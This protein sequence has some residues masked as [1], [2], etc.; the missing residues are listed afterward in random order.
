LGKLSGAWYDRADRL[1]AAGASPG[2][3]R[4]KSG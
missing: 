1:I 2:L 4:Q 3:T